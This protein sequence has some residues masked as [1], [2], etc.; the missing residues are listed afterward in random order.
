MAGLRHLLEV[1]DW[2]PDELHDVLERATH[3][4][5]ARVL[6]GKGAALVFQ[7]PSARTRNST[8]MAVV[9]LG[10]HPVAIRADEV[11]IDERESAEDVAR[12]LASY[13]DLICARTFGHDILERMAAVSS[14]PVVNLLSDDAHPLQAVADLLTIQAALGGVEGRTCAYVGDGN[15]VLRSLALAG[16][17]VGMHVTMSCPPGYRLSEADLDRIRAAGGD[18]TVHDRPE[19]AVRGADV[20]YTDV[21]ASMGQEAEAEQ[22]RRAFEG[23]TIDDALLAHASD[24]AIFLHCLPAHRGEEASAAVVDGPQSRI[25]EQAENRMHAARGALWW[26]V[27]QA[28]AAGHDGGWSPAGA[29]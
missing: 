2:A 24:K 19:D 5:P 22:R 16:A 1:D 9:Q 8:E 25:W 26:L 14:V 28:R 18:A 3:P 11:S 17:M 6:E 29:S 10:G 7:K 15:N 27:D 20:I 21:W 12:T 13:H 4:S 23:F